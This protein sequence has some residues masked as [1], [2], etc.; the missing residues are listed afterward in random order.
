M[1]NAEQTTRRI[2]SSKHNEWFTPE[3]YIASARKVLGGIDLD[4]ASCT[5]A[6]RTVQA[7]RYYTKHDDGLTQPWFGRVWLNPPYGRQAGAF[8]A[9]AIADYQ[10]GEV[11]AV[12]LMLNGYSYQTS[13]FQPLFAYPICWHRGR[14]NYHTP[15]DGTGGSAHGTALVYLGLEPYKFAAEFAKYGPITQPFASC[16]RDGDRSVFSRSDKS[17]YIYV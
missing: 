4:P 11:D 10:A 9:R 7:G 2:K 3:R 15:R 12:I 17:P 13:W 14:V 1:P 5:L 8:V 16:V 6:Q